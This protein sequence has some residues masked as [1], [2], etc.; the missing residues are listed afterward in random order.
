LKTIRS[1]LDERGFIEVNTPKIVAAATEGG[2]ALFPIS[3]FEREAFLSQSPQLYKQMMMATGLD[4]VYEIA[5]ISGLRSMI[6]RST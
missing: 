4:R 5:P 2:T 1:F 6:R 3:Y